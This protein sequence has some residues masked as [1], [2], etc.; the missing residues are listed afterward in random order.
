MAA[1][2]GDSRGPGSG[3]LQ[4]QGLRF[5]GDVVL[6]GALRVSAES[7]IF[8]HQAPRHPAVLPLIRPHIN[9]VTETG[10]RWSSLLWQKTE[11]TFSWFR[12]KGNHWLV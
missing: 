4:R 2:E 3:G 9:G 8:L 7:C 12:Q 11:A 10:R 1:E 5:S 6:W